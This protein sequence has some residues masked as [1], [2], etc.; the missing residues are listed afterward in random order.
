M[1]SRRTLGERVGYSRSFNYC[2]DCASGDHAGGALSVFGHLKEET[3]FR[4]ETG[5]HF[6][7]IDNQ[8][9]AIRALV[10]SGQPTKTDNQKAAE[11]LIEEAR[12]GAI[13]L[14]SNLVKQ[15]GDSFIDASKNSPSAWN[16]AVQFVNYRS[17]QNVYTRTVKII[18][19]PPGS[20]TEYNIVGVPGKPLPTLAHS[21]PAVAPND[22]A[23]YETIG[24]DLNKSLSFGTGELFVS[25]GA[26]LLD[27]QFV[28]HVI[29]SNIEVHYSGKPVRLEDVIFVG[30]VFVLDN[31]Q[32]TRDFGQ[33]L[34][35]SMK[36]D[37]IYPPQPTAHS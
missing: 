12:A 13:S 35:A 3:Q 26:V 9:V 34:L 37:F 20:K 19:S 1:A 17:S 2:N 11:K 31:N 4:T 25:G 32:P 8:L 29:F 6:K 18:P 5:D 15:V 7:E 10:V 16:T 22:A 23:R 21:G 24:K 28:R 14:P 27:N 33:I 30:C 36:I